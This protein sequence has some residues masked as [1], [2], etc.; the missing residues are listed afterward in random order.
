[1]QAEK[2]PYSSVGLKG[3]VR[4]LGKVPSK[5][6]YRSL[7]TDK[8]PGL[9][10][11]WQVHHS[12]PQKYDGIMRDSGINIHT[13][14]YLRGVDPEVHQKNSNE[15]TSWDKSLGRAPTA[16]EIRSFEKQI[17]QKYNKYWH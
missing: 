1:M 16:Q 14:K 7:Y 15:W 8:N 9:S 11:G 17:D 2:L 4:G 5:S 3:P 13:V 10:K 6:N 12:L